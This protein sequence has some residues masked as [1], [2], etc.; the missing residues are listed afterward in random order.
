MEYDLT[1]GRDDS[2]TEKLDELADLCEV[3]KKYRDQGKTPRSLNCALISVC[4]D[5]TGEYEFKSSIT[6]QMLAEMQSK[7]VT[8]GGV[9]G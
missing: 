7:P 4:K 5:I 2:I 9:I 8:S 3:W 6:N 1:Y